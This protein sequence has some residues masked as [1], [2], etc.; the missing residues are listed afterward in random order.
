[1]PLQKLEAVSD[2]E[3]IELC[4]KEGRALVTLDLDFANP[5][6]FRPADYPGIAVLRLPKRPTPDDYQQVVAT[7]V[8]GLERNALAGKLWIV[9]PSRLRVYEPEA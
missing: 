4:R 8:K 7:L 1:M 5:L 3:L 2:A 6:E 9:E